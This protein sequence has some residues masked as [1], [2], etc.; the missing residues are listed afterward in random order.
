[1]SGISLGTA[2][3]V[4]AAVAAAGTAVNVYSNNK[5]Q[6]AQNRANRIQQE[7]SDRAYQQ[8]ISQMRR[9]NQNAVDTTSLLEQ[10]TGS[11]VGSTM[12]TGAQGVDQSQLTLGRANKLL[13][14]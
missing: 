7:A 2:L 13:G 10:N 11:D 3:A 14:G 1:M 4:S 5:Q 8:E 12:L 9:Q 6:K